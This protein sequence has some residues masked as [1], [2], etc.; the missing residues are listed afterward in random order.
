MRRSS[1]ETRGGEAALAAAAVAMLVLLAACSYKGPG[2]AEILREEEYAAYRLPGTATI[3]GQAVLHLPS[4]ETVYGQGCQVRLLPV[5]EDTTKY[6]QSVVLTGE[7]TA[8]KEKSGAVAWVATADTQGRFRFT[9]V[10]AGDYYLTCPMVWL[11]D[12]RT[13]QGIAF[14]RTSVGPG[15]RVRVELTRGT[16]GPGG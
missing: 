13:R 3:D 1:R 15:K 14:A 5:T 9:E 7:I 6:F 4:G 10:P 16:G 12:G 2:R 11:D 8:F